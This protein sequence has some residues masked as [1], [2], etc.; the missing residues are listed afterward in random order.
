MT[1][2][3]VNIL[4]NMSEANTIKKGLKVLSVI[5]KDFWTNVGDLTHSFVTTVE[6]FLN[7]SVPQ[8]FSEINEYTTWRCRDRIESQFALG[9]NQ[10]CM[11]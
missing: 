11:R 1:E 3:I 9:H 4:D 2:N 5:N 7:E 6:T 8:S 10:N